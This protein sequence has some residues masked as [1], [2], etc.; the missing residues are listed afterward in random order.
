MRVVAY[1]RVSTAGQVEE[2]A[3]LGAQE[4]KL[5]H[6]AAAMDLDVVELLQDAGWSAK[7]LERPGLQHA[8]ALL[9][10]GQVEGLL[11]AKLDRLTRSVRDLGELVEGYFSAS[12]KWALLSVGDSIDTRSAGGRL[13][14]N[15]LASVAQWEREI[16]GERTREALGHLKQQGRRLGAP[17]LGATEPESLVV[18]RIIELRQ[19]GLSLQA[20]AAA[21]TAEGHR[22]KRGGR[23]APETVRKVCARITGVAYSA[24]SGTGEFVGLLQLPLRWQLDS[25][26]AGAIDLAC[27]VVP[28]AWWGP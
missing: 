5:R 14:L 3:S 27:M 24:G 12:S 18:R 17:A 22:T 19:G 6:Y 28:S 26:S 13:V 4:A 8:L 16:I 25:F 7:T 9:R 21:L 23:W 2:G 15:V 20:V 10:A 1:L 11:I